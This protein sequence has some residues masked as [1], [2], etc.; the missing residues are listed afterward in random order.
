MKV[1]RLKLGYPGSEGACWSVGGT[2]L[3]DDIASLTVLSSDRA[4]EVGTNSES[5]SS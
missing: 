1:E 5:M 4:V 2:S 3:A